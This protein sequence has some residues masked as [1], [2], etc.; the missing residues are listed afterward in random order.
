MSSAGASQPAHLLPRVKREHQALRRADGTI[1]IGGDIYG[2]ASVIDDP[3]GSLWR[4]IRLV[5]GTRSPGR[6]GG[7]SGQPAE[8]VAAVLDALYHGGFLEDAAAQGSPVLSA[9]ERE[10]YSRNQAFYRWIDLA[11]RTSAWSAQ[12]RI[13][14]ATVVVVG[15]GGGG[16]SVALALAASGVG[17]LHLV[18]HDHVELS[19]LTRQFLYTEADIGGSKVDA[20]VA[21]LRALN[22]TISVTGEEAKVEGVA[23]LRRLAARCDVLALCADQ[24]QEIGHWADTACR[25]VG[26]PWVT[27]G[28][29]GPVTV[30]QTFSRGE[31]ACFECL[32]LR[33]GELSDGAPAAA[34]AP[35]DLVPLGNDDVAAST[36]VSAGLGG[37]MVAHAVLAHITGAPDFGGRSFQF[38]LN[39]VAPHEQRYLTTERR[40]DC[41]VCGGQD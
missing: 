33:S 11:P 2:I 20:A 7:E 14:A 40:P 35:D 1:Q 21:R 22:S 12:E 36:A 26:I 38:G 5:D 25:E 30:A 10:R 19:N 4:I 27:G 29:V 17:T 3:D 15:L 31:G 39:L 41:P 32:H 23:D 24:P 34:V 16:S 37:L 8:T 18:D 6:L 13:K 28:Y 9:Q